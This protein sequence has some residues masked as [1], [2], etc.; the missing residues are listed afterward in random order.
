M[1]VETVHNGEPRRIVC[2]FSDEDLTDEP[3]VV[4]T[5]GGTMRSALL[6]TITA[7]PGRS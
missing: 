4:D 3:H 7:E 5:V 1:T 6:S 2:H